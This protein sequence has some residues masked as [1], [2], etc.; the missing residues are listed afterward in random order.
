MRKGCGSQVNTSF[1]GC[2]ELLLVLKR[3]DSI[4]LY[5]IYRALE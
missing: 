5:V 1:A 3:R 4:A 2:F